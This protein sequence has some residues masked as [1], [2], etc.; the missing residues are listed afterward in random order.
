[1]ARSENTI[2]TE[3]HRYATALASKQDNDK[4]GMH[5]ETW[6][7]RERQG[8]RE[9]GRGRARKRERRN[10]TDVVSQELAHKE[11]HKVCERADIDIP[12]DEMMQ[13][14]AHTTLGQPATF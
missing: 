14:P 5:R 3:L 1:M 11:A 2:K 10:S 12:T 8:E 13:E 7:E 6:G 9:R 4:E